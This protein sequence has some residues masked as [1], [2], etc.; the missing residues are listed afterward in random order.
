MGCEGSQKL[1]KGLKAPFGSHCC[2]TRCFA[3][4]PISYSGVGICNGHKPQQT[5]G[6]LTAK[7]TNASL[8]T[9]LCF[10]DRVEPPLMWSWGSS[11]LI[12]AGN[13]LQ[14]SQRACFKAL[15]TPR[16]CPMSCP[17]WGFLANTRKRRMKS[18][19]RALCQSGTC[20]TPS[21]LG[22]S[23][24]LQGFCFVFKCSFSDW[25][26]ARWKRNARLLQLSTKS[27]C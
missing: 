22:F 2:P 17:Q 23:C 20:T 6:T 14:I 21:R 26:Q 19:T 9:V 15:R 10:P 11:I 24:M 8:H 27:A 5:Q 1:K 18:V 3:S 4:R 16:C 7:E 25:N 12:R 13:T